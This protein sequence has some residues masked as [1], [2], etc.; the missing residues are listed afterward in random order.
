MSGPSA[1]AVRAVWTA[2][3]IAFGIVLLVVAAVLTLILHEA[4]KILAGVKEIWNVGQKIANNT[5]H[6]ALLAET[7]HIAGRILAS[8]KGIVAATAALEA[9]AESCPGC[10]ACVLGPPVR[11]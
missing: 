2:S 6:I 10:P 9:H 1:E 8:A 4:K 7:N 5:I 11:P 3:L